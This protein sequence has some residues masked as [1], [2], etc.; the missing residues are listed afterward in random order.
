MTTRFKHYPP[1]PKNTECKK[2]YLILCNTHDAASSFLD[3][4]E[5]VRKTRKAK[6]MATYEEQDLLRAMLI[7]STAGLDSMVKQ[8]VTDALSEIIERDAG[9]TQMFK[10]F[11]E[12]RLKKSEEL[13]RQFL[14]DILGDAKPRS[15]LIG[16]LVSDLTSRSLQSTE[17]L[18]RVA[19]HFNIPSKDLC[20]DIPYLTRIFSARNQ[21]A[22]EM[23]AE[24]AQSKRT[25]RLRAKEMMTE[26]TNEV[27]Q[28][29]G[30]FVSQV[31]QRIP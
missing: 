3:I 24:F 17:Q 25:R 29:S 12:R 10:Q 1:E 31:D 2:A 28:I 23:D 30:K 13:D 26:F 5:E 6:G 20:T 8:L 16:E 14:A 22:H 15:R 9:A 27:F 4:F 19:S 7:F 11:I 18:M 21:I